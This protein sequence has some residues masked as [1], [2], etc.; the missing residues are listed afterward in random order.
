VKR[1][2]TG[3]SRGYSGASR[4]RRPGRPTEA[5][6]LIDALTEPAGAVRQDGQRYLRRHGILVVAI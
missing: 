1:P 3:S 5:S 6:P 2:A 4:P